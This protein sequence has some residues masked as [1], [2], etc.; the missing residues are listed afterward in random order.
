MKTYIAIGCLALLGSCQVYEGT[1]YQDPVYGSVQPRPKSTPAVVGEPS[2]SNPDVAANSYYD[3]NSGN[4]T[5]N[6]YGNY[7]DY[8]Y[9]NRLNRFYNPSGFGY[10]SP[11]YNGF[12]MNYGFGYPGSGFGLSFG[13]G[14]G[15]PFYGGMG[16]Y[17]PWYNGWPYYNNW[18]YYGYGGYYNGFNNGYCPGLY[19]GNY[20]EFSRPRVFNGG[21]RGGM[22]GRGYA[23]RS[24][25]GAR[26]GGGNSPQAPVYQNGGV[27]KNDAYPARTVRG[28]RSSAPQ[29]YSNPASADP[30]ENTQPNN[31][32]VTRQRQFSS[33]MQPHESRPSAQP[34]NDYSR[35]SYS[36][37]GGGGSRG[38][39][40][41]GFGG[42][43]RRPR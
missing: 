36:A 6:Y 32:G 25:V 21:P 13:Y 7:N 11:Y 40:G 3:P 33:P 43:G 19:S 20:S 12:G 41:S 34:R 38:S 22:N 29:Q 37:P 30:S 42:G 15:S 1:A 24:N 8:S 31:T 35:P 14:W 39:G 18:P 26:Q 5:N 28:S 16:W 23:G 2:S 27:P 17:D 4:V 10:F 9:T